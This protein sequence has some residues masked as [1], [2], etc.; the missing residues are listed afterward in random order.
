M[1]SKIGSSS[2]HQSQ[3][4]EEEEAAKNNFLW[5]VVIAMGGLLN[6]VYT[7]SRVILVNHDDISIQS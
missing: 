1:L 2:L 7:N 5:V 4:E 3:E 6:V